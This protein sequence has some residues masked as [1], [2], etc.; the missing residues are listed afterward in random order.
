MN[1]LLLYYFSVLQK[2][3][4]RKA[5]DEQ[6]LKY[7][8]LKTV[9]IQLKDVLVEKNLSIR[10]LE[11]TADAGSGTN[12]VDESQKFKAFRDIFGE[13]NL[14]ILRSIQSSDASSDLKFI[15]LTIEFM[16]G[17]ASKY[18]VLTDRALKNKPDGPAKVMSP[19]KKK[20]L[21]NIFDERIDSANISEQEK[22][23]RK[24]DFGKLYSKALCYLRS[25]DDKGK[26]KSKS[27][28]VDN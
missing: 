27:Y 4:F 8:K 28:N 14:R 13:E 23:R 24:K 1:W 6:K 11:N 26:A 22:L 3:L 20:S 2:M 16:Y 12:A 9:Y 15:R 17:D 5:L 21:N 7:R 25:K 19:Q 10:R 18:R